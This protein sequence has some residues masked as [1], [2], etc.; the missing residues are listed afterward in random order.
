M[1]LKICLGFYGPSEGLSYLA[2]L[3]GISNLPRIAYGTEWDCIQDA[4]IVNR[5][6]NTDQNRHLTNEYTVIN[7]TNSD[8]KGHTL[9]SGATWAYSQMCVTNVDSTQKRC[10]N[11]KNCGI[12][13]IRGGGYFVLGLSKILLVYLIWTQ[14]HC[15]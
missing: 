15:N 4:K 14:F 10:M 7:W 1:S 12:I 8:H 13:L 6:T 9:I 3:Y 11:V 5:R 2:A